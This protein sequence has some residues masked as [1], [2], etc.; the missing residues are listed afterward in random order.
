MYAVKLI[1]KPFRNMYMAKRTVREL[2]I[3]RELSALE[4]NVFTPIIHDIIAPENDDN[5]Y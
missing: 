4:V 5:P 1:D 2:N 3:L